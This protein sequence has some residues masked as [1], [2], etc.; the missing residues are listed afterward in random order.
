MLGDD[1]SSHSFFPSAPRAGDGSR[2]DGS[3]VHPA[4]DGQGPQVAAKGDAAGPDAA[5]AAGASRV[6]GLSGR[7][8]VSS[9]LVAALLF[10]FGAYESAL[11]FGHKTVPN[12]D[13]PAFL[14]VGRELLSFEIP[15]SFKRA[16]VVG[17][18]E[19]GLSRFV[20][21]PHPDLTAGWLLNAILHPF[22]VVLLWLIARRIVGRWAWCIVLIVVI[23]PWWLQNLREPVAETTL[24]FFVAATFYAIFTRSRWRYVLAAVTTMVRYDAAA[25]LLVTA[26]PDLVRSRTGRERIR[27]VIFSLAAVIPLGLWLLGTALHFDREGATHY[28][29]EMG[30]NAPFWNALG[31]YL[32]CIWTVVVSPLGRAPGGLSGS[33]AGVFSLCLG[34]PLCVGVCLGLMY[35]VLERRWEV[36]GLLTFMLAYLAAHVLH[37]FVQP[38]FCSTL[39]WMVLLVAVYGLRSGWR[40][41]RTRLGLFARPVIVLQGVSVLLVGLWAFGVALRLSGMAA[42][43]ARSVSVPYVAVALVCLLL[44]AEWFGSERMRLPRDALVPA[45]LCLVILSNQY[46]LVRLMG[47]GRQDIEFKLLADWY[48]NSARPRDKL[49][50]TYADIVGL[51]LPNHGENLISLAQLKADDEAGFLRNCHKQGVTYLAWDSR[52]G[53]HPGDRYYQYYGLAPLAPLA[54]PENWGPFEF[55]VEFQVSAERW[56]NIFRWRPSESDLSVLS[57]A[58]SDPERATPA[59]PTGPDDVS[60]EGSA[61][62]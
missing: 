10:G 8:R 3:D 56:I 16:P 55:I 62:K 44:V 43:S 41:L 38:R 33:A 34:I 35:A 31:S 58:G 9:C 28:W 2:V 19:A 32:T 30:T 36:L 25:L 4:P 18:L 20:G 21:G 57:G 23:N 11:Y 39:L 40:A 29:N 14:R 46:L 52:L 24:H 12:S 60:R 53:C 15:S 48:R 37:S 1:H 49:A 42:F 22:T 26:L 17:L 59:G 27:T 61:G 50:T 45:S 13:F 7:Q 47:N 54:M 6:P 5:P 51:Y